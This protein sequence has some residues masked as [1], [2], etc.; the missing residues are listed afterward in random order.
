VAVANIG[1]RVPLWR[2]CLGVAIVR[3]IDVLLWLRVPLS[4]SIK[5]DVI[6]LIVW[7]TRFVVRGAG[8]RSP[9]GVR[10]GEKCRGS[11]RS[12]GEPNQ[13]PPTFGD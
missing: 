3:A 7:T 10:A 13:I 12:F 8:K 4:A 6:R 1:Y 2:L 9:P 5:R 11:S